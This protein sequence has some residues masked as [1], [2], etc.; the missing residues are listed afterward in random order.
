MVLAA[1]LFT[2]AAPSLLGY[3]AGISL[4]I[5]VALRVAVSNAESAIEFGGK[6][7]Y[8]RVVEEIKTLD[9]E[10]AGVRSRLD[11]ANQR[12]PELVRAFNAAVDALELKSDDL[13]AAQKI[14]AD[15]KATL[16]AAHE[17]VRQCE[18]AASPDCDDDPDPDPDPDPGPWSDRADVWGDPH[19]VTF[20]GLAFDLQAEGEF[21]MTASS[22][23]DFVVQTQTRFWSANDAGRL[24]TV[25]VIEQVAVRIGRDVVVIRSDGSTPTVNGAEWDGTGTLSGGAS[26]DGTRIEAEADV[27]V[28]AHPRASGSQPYLDI[29]IAIGED[30]AGSLTGLLGNA[31]GDVAD[32]GAALAAFENFYASIAPGAAVEPSDRLLAGPARPYIPPSRSGALDPAQLA[33]ATAAC[34]AAGWTDADGAAFAIYD[35]AVTGDLSF[36]T[37]DRKARLYGTEIV[38]V[39]EDLNPAYNAQL[40]TDG[41][42]EA[43]ASGGSYKTYNT[44]VLVGG[45]RV[46]AGSV[47]VIHTDFWQAAEGRQSLNLSGDAA[48]TIEQAVATTP[49]TDYLLSLRVAGNADGGATVKELQVIWDG[50]VVAEPSFDITG[51]TRTDMGWASVVVPVTATTATSTLR[52]VSLSDEVFGP[53]VDDVSLVRAPAG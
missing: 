8:D 24:G 41:G 19:L 42:F 34:N 4:A 46:T 50:E 18:A 16:A 11:T 22:V 39:V 7:K 45:W 33:A 47:D 9:T 31:N 52:L 3:A 38:A 2:G 10:L 15:A 35:A 12:L 1:V 49:G 51:R 36:C 37:A 29:D 5:G 25:S 43:A 26:F 14:L 27:A 6:T 44:G 40:V 20:D 30:R 48:G 28:E 13:D 53:V 17:E 32:D 23:D 21:T